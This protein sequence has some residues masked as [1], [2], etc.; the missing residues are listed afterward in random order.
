MQSKISSL[1]GALAIAARLRL[2]STR[3]AAV[4]EAGGRTCADDPPGE[5]GPVVLPPAGILDTAIH[6]VSSADLPAYQV[7]EVNDRMRTL[8]A[9]YPVGGIVLF[10]H[11]IKDPAQLAAFQRDLRALPG[12]PLLCIDEEGGRVARLAGNPA[13]GLPRYES[14]AALGGRPR[15]DGGGPHHRH[16]FGPLRL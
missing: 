9:D 1:L 10:A 11:N 6:Y 8:A 4:I 2:S 15:G 7:Q 16:V 5:G 3:E 12:R 13:F 14:M